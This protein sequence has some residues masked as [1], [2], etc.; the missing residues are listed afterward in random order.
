MQCE[1]LDKNNPSKDE[2][3]VKSKKSTTRNQMQMNPSLKNP[4]VKNYSTS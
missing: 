2:A 1:E 4:S 3:A